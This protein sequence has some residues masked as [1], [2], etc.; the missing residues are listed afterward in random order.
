[1]GL[2]LLRQGQRV[3][4]RPRATPGSPLERAREQSMADDDL[5]RDSSAPVPTAKLPSAG[6][7]SAVAPPAVRQ[8]AE[9]A[10]DA[11]VAALDR[12]EVLRAAPGSEAAV[13]GRVSSAGAAPGTRAET[14]KRT[15]PLAM[16]R[17]APLAPGDVTGPPQGADA[18][19]PPPRDVALAA[20][21]AMS[22]DT[23]PGEGAEIDLRPFGPY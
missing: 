15:E 14:S 20:T 13:A 12:T 4:G 18:A 3:R 2:G 1:A 10:A 21:V 6:V 5:E 22:D 23:D 9:P 19:R 16:A 17:T 7:S 8:P 11:Q